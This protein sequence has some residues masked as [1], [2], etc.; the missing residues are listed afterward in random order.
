MR[1]V[2]FAPATPAVLAPASVP[3]AASSFA[4]L[5][6]A[7][8]MPVAAEFASVHALALALASP[9]EAEAVAQSSATQSRVVISAAQAYRPLAAQ[10]A[11]T[12]AF[13]VRKGRKRSACAALTRKGRVVGSAQRPA[14]KAKPIINVAAKKKAPKRR[15]VWLSTQSRV[16]R[17]VT[18]N[19][20]T[21]ARS[22]RIAARAQTNKAPVRMLRLAA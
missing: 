11:V 20:V 4:D 15:H 2:G 17:P 1:A 21:L 8:A 3:P 19:V 5:A 9:L 10:L 18:S 14:L 16:I 22:P 13:N 12:A 6:Y 7:A